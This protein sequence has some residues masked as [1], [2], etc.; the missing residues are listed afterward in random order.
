MSA[1]HI[2]AVN[3]LDNPAAFLN[4]LQFE[5]HYE[6][7]GDLQE[8]AT[9]RPIALLPSTASQERLNRQG[10]CLQISNGSSYMWDRQSQR[11]MIRSWTT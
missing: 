4:P 5:I 2:T 8:G 9:Q 11:N 10:S 3:V 6:C 7:L 1:V